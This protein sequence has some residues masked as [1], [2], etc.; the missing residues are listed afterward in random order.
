MI[1]LTTATRTKNANED[2]IQIADMPISENPSSCVRP[3]QRGC[4]VHSVKRKVSV[5]FKV[6][7]RCKFSHSVKNYMEQKEKDIGELCP[8]FEA[9]GVCNDGWRCRWLSGHICKAEN[10]EEGAVDGWKLVV[11]KEVPSLTIWGR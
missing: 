5:M 9:I 4:P 8:V 7:A 10:G 3:M 2:R 1:Q 6:D 11:N